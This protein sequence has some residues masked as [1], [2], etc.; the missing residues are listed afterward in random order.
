[1]VAAVERTADL[2]RHTVD[3]LLDL[4]GL[5]SG[6]V[7]LTVV[8]MDLAAVVNEAVALAGEVPDG[9]RVSSDPCP[10]LIIDG[11]AGRLR[12]VV[13]DL[14]SNAVR[15]SPDGGRV[16]VHLSD[17]DGVAELTVADEGIGTP[18]DERDRV[19][20]RFYRASNVRHQ[21]ITGSGLGLSLART[22]VRLHGGTITLTDRRPRGTTALV[23]LPRPADRA[24]QRRRT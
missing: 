24:G 3:T 22:I 11:D 17:A 13:G 2:L 4:A 21:G 19:F 1:M 5:D 20:E 15:Y 18:A 7:G 12:Q 14:L 23:R 8:R 9:I 16:T 10:G 6:H